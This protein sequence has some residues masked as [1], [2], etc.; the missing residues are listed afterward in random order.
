MDEEIRKLI[1]FFF[2]F[3]LFSVESKEKGTS[4]DNHQIYKKAKLSYKNIQN[5]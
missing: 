2:I 1:L 4:D 5:L 3:L